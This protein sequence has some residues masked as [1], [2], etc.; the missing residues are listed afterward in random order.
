[1]S[2]PKSNCIGVSAK[3]TVDIAKDFTQFERPKILGN[4]RHN[5]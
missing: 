2:T 5:G 3:K 1:M 4:T